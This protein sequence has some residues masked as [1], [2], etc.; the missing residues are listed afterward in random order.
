MTA[1]RAEG[2]AKYYGSVHA[3]DGLNLTVEPGIVFGFLGYRRQR[4]SNHNQQ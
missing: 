1:I 4:H 2:L 3:L